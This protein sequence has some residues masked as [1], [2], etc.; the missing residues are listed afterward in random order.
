MDNF[1]SWFFDGLGTEIISL[2]IGAITG[3]LI[4]FAAGR[5]SHMSQKQNA[6]NGAEQTQ[7]G[8]ANNAERA[9]ANGENRQNSVATVHQTQKAG[10]NSKQTQV[11]SSKNA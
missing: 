6:G 10:D 2:I 8:T 4:G 7:K 5:K 1:V 9:N 3:G 11:G